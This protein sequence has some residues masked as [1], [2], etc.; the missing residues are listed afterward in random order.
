MLSYSKLPSFYG[1]DFLEYRIEN[2]DVP[3]RESGIGRVVIMVGNKDFNENQSFLL[4]NA[5]SPNDDG[6]N[7]RFVISGLGETEESTL[8][9]F[10]RWGTIVYRSQG[11]QYDNSWDG[12]SNV[13]A[14]VSI[15]KELP[16]G[17]YF[18]VYSVKKNVNDSIQTR[19][20]SGYVELR[21]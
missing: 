11:K 15:G 2:L 5:F 3:G 18:Y 4:P 17:V 19:N 10:N 1:E 12:T 21:R 9:V 14:M 7:D 6:I 16:N 8:G 20:Y 13:G